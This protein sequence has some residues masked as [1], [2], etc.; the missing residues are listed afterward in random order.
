M[1][2]TIDGRP[3]ALK[4][5]EFDLLVMLASKAGQP[6][7]QRELAEGLWQEAKPTHS[8]H[9][10]VI[11][12]RL[13]AKLAASRSYRLQTFRKRGYALAPRQSN[14]IEDIKRTKDGLDVFDD[15]LRYART[16]AE[17]DPDDLERMKWYGVFHRRQTPGYFMLRPRA[18]NG[19][20]TAAQAIEIGELSERFGR[21]QLDITTRQNI[22]LRW[23]RIQDIPE[24][25]RR[26]DSVALEYRQSGMDNVRNITG[27]P[28]AG[29]GT[30]ELLDASSITKAVQDAI[31]GHKEFSNLPRKFNISITGCA[32]DCTTSQ[33]QDLSLVPAS[34]DGRHG[35]NVKAGG[36]MGSKS[37]R[38]ADDIDIFV[39]PERA[40]DLCLAIIRLFRDEGS[41]DD[42]QT[43]RLGMLIEEWGVA[44][45]RAQLEAQVGPLERAGVCGFETYAGDHIGVTQQK[46]DNLYALGCVVPVGRIR[47]RDFA[48]FGR[49]AEEYGSGELRLT[50]QQNILIV[51]VN[52]GR[53]AALLEEPLLQKYSPV[54]SAWSR[55]TVSCTGKDFCHF[56]LI[57]TKGYAQELS[58]QME[59]LMPLDSPLRV[60][61]SGCSHGCGQHLVADIG[62][63]AQ[64]LAIGDVIV[65]AA[66]VFI[67]GR[68]GK[69]ARLATKVL[70]S[71][72]LSELPLRLK[73]ILAAGKGP[74]ATC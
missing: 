42:R 62:I 2:V 37:S 9:L 10:S 1:R 25:F 30:H 18:P 38:F 63:Q 4:V 11:I 24:V 52:G 28:M 7:T 49:L 59:S 22:Q 20:L 55:R 35:F 39:P 16:G 43:A 15:I 57:D 71:V 50:N 34:K 19:G 3:L 65:D 60:H 69:D 32:S 12:A 70:D 56:A 51:N 23:M 5:Q 46:K 73:E 14:R 68:L 29:L 58:R 45:F 40:L 26:L 33:I 36:A 17:I 64:R 74:A 44:K 31:V 66:D 41:R 47:G 48:A 13:R 72:P 8:R 6:L 21:G 27:C 54:P 53:L 67:G 61:W